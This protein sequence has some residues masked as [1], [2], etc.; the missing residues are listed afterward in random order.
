MMDGVYWCCVLVFLDGTTYH[1]Y[2]TGHVTRC[3]EWMADDNSDLAWR[4]MEFV[5]F[6]KKGGWEV[7]WCSVV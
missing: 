4:W 6:G 7:W 5:W 1:G 3:M 2:G